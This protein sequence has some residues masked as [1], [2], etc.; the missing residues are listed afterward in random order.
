MDK[1]GKMSLEE[2]MEQDR[3]CKENNIP[4]GPGCTGCPGE[5]GVCADNIRGIMGNLKTH[6]WYM[7]EKSTG[8]EVRIEM[9]AFNRE[10]LEENQKG[11]ENP[12]KYLLINEQ[13]LYHRL[14][15]AV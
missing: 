1:H 7:V 6:R 13:E 12:D 15:E 2:F 11:M 10:I 8:Y 4:E 5:H 9:Y 14:T 3:Y